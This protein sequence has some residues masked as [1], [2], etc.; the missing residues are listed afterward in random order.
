MFTSTLRVVELALEGVAV[1][2]LSIVSVNT[3]RGLVIRHTKRHVLQPVRGPAR[4]S[5]FTGNL[6]DLFLYL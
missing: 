3:V 4:S 1:L 2:I 5:I 6:L